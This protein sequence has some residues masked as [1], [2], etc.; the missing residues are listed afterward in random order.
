MANTIGAS[1]PQLPMD[2][3][4]AAPVAQPVAANPADA[5]RIAAA[6]AQLRGTESGREVAD[7]LARNKVDIRVMPHR[8]FRA[9][10]PGAGAIYD[11]KRHQISMP[12][13]ALG[14]SALV[15][16]IAH[17]GKHALDFQ[18][19]PHWTIQ[20][21]SLIAG[22][23]GDGAKALVTLNNPITG[24]LDSLTARQNEDEVNAYHLQAQVAHELGRNESSWALGQATDGTPLPLEDVRVRVATDDLYRMDPTRRLVLGAGLGLGVTSIAAI[25]AQ[26]LAGKLRPGSFLASHS[27]PVYALGGVATAAWVINDQLR[28]RRLESYGK[29]AGDKPSI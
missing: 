17:E 22:R 16:T 18:D 25:G 10:Y 8:D 6:V 14:S 19:R 29:F 28:S 27:W 26:A 2:G 4:F 20:S 12:Q 11:P 21:L 1:A 3:A 13:S 23:A 5:A 15:T 9:H 7:F 24:W